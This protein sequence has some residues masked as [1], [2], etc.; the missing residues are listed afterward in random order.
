M[1]V[2]GCVLGGR[3]IINAIKINYC[4]EDQSNTWTDFNSHNKH[5]E[6]FLKNILYFSG[7][8]HVLARLLL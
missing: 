1:Y 3:L 8:T 2:C 6:S 7:I 4:L 5:S